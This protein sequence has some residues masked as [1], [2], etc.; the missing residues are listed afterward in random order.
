MVRAKGELTFMN[1]SLQH[2]WLLYSLDK[3][4]STPL[5][6]EEL[7]VLHFYQFG[8]ALMSIRRGSWAAGLSLLVS[9]CLFAGEDRDTKVRN[10]RQAFQDNPS[11]FY[12]NLDEG[13]V[14]AEAARKPL[15]VIFRC[16]P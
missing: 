8:S 2:T 9:C 10:D 16:I 5:F 4:R 14:T 15:L 1:L 6:C 12:N 11:W 3:R 13:V 7:F